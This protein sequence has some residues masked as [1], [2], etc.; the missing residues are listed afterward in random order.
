MEAVKDERIQLMYDIITDYVDSLASI[1][2]AFNNDYA[3]LSRATL[4]SNVRLTN[5]IKGNNINID[6]YNSIPANKISELKDLLKRLNR[7]GRASTILPHSFLSSLVAQYDHLIGQLIRFIYRINPKQLCESESKVSYKDLFTIN[8]IDKIRDKIIQD[9]VE[10]IIRKSHEDQICD[11][12]KMINNVPLSKVDFWSDFVEITQRRNLLVHCKGRVSAQYI[13]ICKNAGVD[14]LPKEGDILDVDDKYFNKA[15]HVL[16]KMGVMLSQVIT[17]KLFEKDEVLPEID[18]I[19]NQVIYGVLEEG[20]YEL[21]IDLSQ[22]ALAPKTKHQNNLDKVYF[23]LNFAQAYKWLGQQDKCEAEL[24]KFDFSG[25]CADIMIAKYALEDDIDNVVLSMKNIGTHSSIMTKEAYMSWLIFKE[26]RKERRFCQT[27]EE[28]FGENISAESLT[29][30]ESE[31]VK[32][33][34]EYNTEEHAR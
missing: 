25:M 11:L 21:A 23:V 32:S 17:R 8:D 6:D 2:E 1:R 13:K 15:F 26:M 14:N 5:F 20:D 33:V 28:I 27:Y 10:A 19:L 7:V 34:E 29:P 24:R 22:F 12:E 18:T 4:I 30:E 9:K 31:M 3:L 16:Y